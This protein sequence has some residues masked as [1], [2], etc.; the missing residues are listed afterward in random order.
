MAQGRG[1]CLGLPQEGGEIF[2]L[3]YGRMKKLDR[4]KLLAELDKN[5]LDIFHYNYSSNECFVRLGNDEEILLQLSENAVPKK[6][7]SLLIHILQDHA[8]Y[9]Q[10][11]ARY[12]KDFDIDIENNYFVYGIYVGEFCLKA[13][14]FNTLNGFSISL[15]R[16][17]S[18]DPLNPGV[19][20][21]RFKIDGTP[22]GVDL[23]FE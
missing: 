3:R 7:I 9:I 12:L 22:F 2:N 13:H 5:N 10:K 1:G 11:A 21:V 14:G 19:F 18:I 17:D 15:K 8:A 20:T 6:S 4:E 16:W 23:W